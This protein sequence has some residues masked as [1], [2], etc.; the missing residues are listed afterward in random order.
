MFETHE[1]LIKNNTFKPPPPPLSIKY[2]Q[3]GTY[4]KVRMYTPETL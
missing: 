1:P 3:G 4:H 2:C